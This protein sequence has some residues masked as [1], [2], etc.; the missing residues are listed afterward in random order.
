MYEKQ[1]TETM[2]V[3][4][5]LKLG[6]Q[7]IF[8]RIGCNNEQVKH[9]LG[10]N[11]VTESNMMQYL[12][13]IELR[14]NEILKMYNP[15]DTAAKPNWKPTADEKKKVKD[16]QVI[17]CP[18]V[19]SDNRGEFAASRQARPP[20]AERDREVDDDSMPLREADFM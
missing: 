13:I 12:D 7:N 19:N 9:L 17:E 6:I 2:N 5:A 16:A 15:T 10:K 4:R 20:A 11:E 18:V 3:I 14:T 1:Y 8:N